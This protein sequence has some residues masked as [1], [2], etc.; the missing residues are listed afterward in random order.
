MKRTQ[1]LLGIV[2]GGI[3]LAIILNSALGSAATKKIVLAT[4]NWEP[5]Y[6]EKL[7]NGGYIA[8]I[9]REAFQRVGYEVEIK[10]VPWKRALEQAK[11]GRYDGLLGAWF[12][13]ERAQYF[14]FTEPIDMT[15]LSFFKQTGS[16]ILYSTLK[17]L[18]PYRIGVTRG[19]AHTKEFDAAV[20]LT[21]E[22]VTTSSQNIQ[23]LSEGRIDLFVE[24]R[25]VVQYLIRNDFLKLNGKIVEVKPPLQEKP[26]YNAISKKVVGYEHIIEDFNRGLKLLKDDGTF[27]QILQK[28]GF[29]SPSR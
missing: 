16:P 15:T 5:Y 6:G 23:K 10:W 21:K 1:T 2:T 11:E 28:Y 9:T 26:L 12:S 27:D 3:A 22:E 14:A 19:Y 17:D 4:L 7:E 20:Y 8:E 13:E 25:R 24:D 18:T 29:S